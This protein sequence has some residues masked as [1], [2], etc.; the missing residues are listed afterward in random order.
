M[1]GYRVLADLVV[2]L[3]FLFVVFVV[4]GLFVVFIGLDRRWEWVRN[5]WF[6]SVH[7]AAIAFVVAQSWLGLTCPLTTLEN[8]LRRQAGEATYPGAFIV[9]WAHR[10]LFYDAP[11]W[12][13]TVCYSLFGLAVVAAFWFAPPR[14]PFR[15]SR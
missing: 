1:I 14:W 8:S 11:E 9:Y 2:V 5:F 6:R 12:I 13:F 3:H 10:M 4:L 7:L 15:R